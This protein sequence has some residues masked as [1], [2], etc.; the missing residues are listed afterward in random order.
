[1]MMNSSGGGTGSGFG[2]LLLDRMSEEGLIS[3]SRSPLLNICILPSENIATNCLESYNSVLH[4]GRQYNQF[5]SLM[6]VVLNNEAISKAM[7]L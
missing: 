4:L 3:S 6:T 2:S 7:K 5:D 1:M